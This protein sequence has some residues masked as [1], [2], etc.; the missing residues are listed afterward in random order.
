MGEFLVL[1]GTFITHRWWAVVGTTAVVS[2]A[3]YLFWAYQRVFHG[4]TSEVNATVKD[5]TW[6]EIGMVAPLLAGIVF[7][8]VYPK[9]FFDRVNPSVEYLLGHVQQAAP[10]AHVPS[11]GSSAIKYTVPAD[12][13]VDVPLSTGS[14]NPSSSSQQASGGSR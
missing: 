11:Q 12:Q 3:I 1:V 7:L 10:N 2:A 4:R 13:N 6:R 14:S 5:I 9:P 8:G